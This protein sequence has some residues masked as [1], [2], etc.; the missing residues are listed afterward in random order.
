M[1][2]PAL[3]GKIEERAVEEALVAT[4]PAEVQELK[5]R[6]GAEEVK[7]MLLQSLQSRL[8]VE[9]KSLRALEILGSCT[10]SWSRQDSRCRLCRQ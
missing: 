3:I 10:Q 6:K 9:Q 5:R 2:R 1:L 8:E 4:E 7:V